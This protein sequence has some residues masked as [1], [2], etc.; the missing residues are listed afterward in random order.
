MHEFVKLLTGGTGAA[1]IVF[2][3]VGTCHITSI[4]YSQRQRSRT[5]VATNELCMCQLFVFHRLDESTLEGFLSE[6][7]L[8]IHSQ[9]F[10]LAEHKDK[11]NGVTPLIF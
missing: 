11:K 3:S 2:T 1:G 4:G 9:A 7:V 8:K 5:G 6:D 10:V